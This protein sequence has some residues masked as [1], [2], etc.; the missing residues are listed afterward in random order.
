MSKR[1]KQQARKKELVVA[2]R[3]FTFVIVT[4]KTDKQADVTSKYFARCSVDE[5]FSERRASKTCP[6]LL[7]MMTFEKLFI[8]YFGF[9]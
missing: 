1:L 7:W 6:L 5:Q 9:D 2:V 3:A 4:A 8:H